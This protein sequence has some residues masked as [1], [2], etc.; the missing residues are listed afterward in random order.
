MISKDSVTATTVVAVD[1]ATAFEV[2]TDEVDL[3][4]GQG[5]RFRFRHDDSGTLRF[6]GGADGRLVEVFDEAAKD[7]YEV[8]RVRVW[9]PA[10][11]LVFEFRAQAFEPGESTEV[12]VRFERVA[13]G[14]RVTVEHRGWA[15]LR[16]DHP[17]RH[18][19]DGAAFNNMMGIWW[20]DLLAAASRQAARR[21]GG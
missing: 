18:A 6:D 2:F 12:E 20:G 16:D 10:K 9:E 21:K 7:V 1:P 8:G 19:L 11:R 17:V 4:W 14:T 5:P 13:G 3:W 15:S